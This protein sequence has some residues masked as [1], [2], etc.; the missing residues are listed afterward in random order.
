[1]RTKDLI[2][3]ADNPEFISGIYNYCDRWCERCPFTS[4]C[5]VYAMENE[6]TDDP[7]G[8]DI[9]NAEFWQKLGSIFQQAREMISAWAE[10]NGVDLSAASLEPE[11]QEHHRKLRG[12]E[13]HELCVAAKDYAASVN[14]WFAEEILEVQ[15]ADDRVAADADESENDEMVN[16]ATE[17]IRWY[18]YQIAAKTMLAMMS[19]G[20]E[21]EEQAEGLPRDSD[22]SIKVA[23]IATDRSIS[24]WRLMQIARPIR[25]ESVTPLLLALERLRQ[26]TEQIFPEARDFLRPGFDEN[27]DDPVN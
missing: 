3:L 10:E 24:G 22:G 9:R 26:S 8:S 25:A 2:D 19:R 6:E 5:L 1:M 7:A 12:A 17:V 13:D 27:P 15:G 14:E 11:I 21:E 20:D 4:R 18:Q 16:D 23:L